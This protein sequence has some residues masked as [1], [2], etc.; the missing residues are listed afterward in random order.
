MQKNWALTPG[1]LVQSKDS[2]LFLL[3]LKE[4]GNLLD[5]CDTVEGPTRIIPSGTLKM[6]SSGAYKDSYYSA[7]KVKNFLI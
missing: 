6:V 2:Y 1:F 4:L 5:I 7:N 3:I